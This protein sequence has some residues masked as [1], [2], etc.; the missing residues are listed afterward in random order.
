MVHAPPLPRERGGAWKGMEGKGREGKG[1]E[2]KGRG[3][4]REQGEEKRVLDEV[5]GET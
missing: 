1:R 2:G 4:D 3:R 5:E